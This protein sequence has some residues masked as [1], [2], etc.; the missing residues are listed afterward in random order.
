MEGA[1]ISA[2]IVLDSIGPNGARLT[3]LEVTHPR[4][5][6]ADFMTHRNFSRN[7]S[8]S[9]AIP[10][11]QLMAKIEAAPMMPVFWGKNQKGMSASEELVG[12][13]RAEAERLWI[14]GRDYCVK[15]AKRLGY[16]KEK[17]GLNLHKQL[18]NRVVE[19][20]MFITVVLTATEF[21]N[22]F[23]LRVEA[24]A[25]PEIDLPAKLAKKAIESSEPQ[26]LLSGQWH[27]P[28]VT[29]FDEED[30]RSRGFS[31]ERLCNISV[32]RCAAVSYLKQ[33]S[34]KDALDDENRANDRLRPS[35]HM[36]FDR[37]TEVLTE[38][39]WKAWV[40]V[41]TED[42]LLAVNPSTQAAHFEKPLALHAYHVQEPLYFIAGQQLDLAVTA[43]HRMVVSARKN[44]GTWT[45]FGF[46]EAREIEG[47]PRRYLKSVHFE[48]HGDVPAY[49]RSPAF[50]RLMGFFVGDGYTPGGNQISFHLKKQ[51]K[52]D[53]LHSLGFPTRELAH[54][55]LVVEMPGLGNWFRSNCYLSDRQKKIPEWAL[56]L[57]DVQAEALLDGLRNSD[58][59]SRRRTWVYSTT[60]QQV[61]DVLQALL[62]LHGKVGSFS[63]TNYNGGRAIRVNVS[64]RVTPRV[65]TNQSGRSLSYEESFRAYEGM[66]YC[67]TTSTG[68]LL[69]RRNGHVVVSGNSPFEHVAQAMSDYAWAKYARELSEAWIQRRVPVGNLWGWKQYRKMIAN[70]HDF[71]RLRR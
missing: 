17:G 10:V 14:E 66:V 28:Y 55:K 58:G 63:F 18:A 9:R 33:D 69:V 62:H 29:R 32:G 6:H 43:N 35:G 8:S 2:K 60:S 61:A 3:T 46:E 39:G 15:L 5:I 24:G 12:D 51:R 11:E 22:Y 59:S 4:M 16:S 1:V 20:W 34:S 30:L 48:G 64:E 57:S 50:M 49:D 44:D 70:E 19:S 56:A 31:E 68:A 13:D 27:L 65:E 47:K 7:A 40:D 36:C 71:S 21:D 52:I 54:N 37:E 26:K 23:A 41:D 45:P 38:T 25:Q 67:A 42:R 53:F